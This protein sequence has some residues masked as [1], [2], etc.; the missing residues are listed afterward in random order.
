VFGFSARPKWLLTIPQPSCHCGGEVFF[1]CISGAHVLACSDLHTCSAAIVAA[2]HV[3]DVHLHCWLPDP[4]RVT[5]LSFLSWTPMVTW[6]GVGRVFSLVNMATEIRDVHS[7]ANSEHLYMG[8]LVKHPLVLPELSVLQGLSV[9]QDLSVLTASAVFML[10]TP[11]CRVMLASWVGLG[12]IP[13][14]VGTEMELPLPH[15]S[16]VLALPCCRVLHLLEVPPRLNC[17][18]HVQQFQGQRHSIVTPR[19]LAVA[20]GMRSSAHT[21]HWSVCALHAP[22]GSIQPTAAASVP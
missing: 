13:T 17:W 9:L 11:H 20:A 12:G 1:A 16:T 19:C 3:G 18:R 21:A 6:N 7:G 14:K 5:R 10:S 2:S 8:P 22:I 4:I 15:S